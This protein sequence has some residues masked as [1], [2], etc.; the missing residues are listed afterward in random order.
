[1]KSKEYDES[2]LG[3]KP[4]NEDAGYWKIW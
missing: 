4:E 1:M 2:K 3:I